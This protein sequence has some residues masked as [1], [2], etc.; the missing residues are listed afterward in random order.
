MPETSRDGLKICLYILLLPFCR[1][2][3][4]SYLCLQGYQETQLFRLA[5]NETNSTCVSTCWLADTLKICWCKTAKIYRFDKFSHVGMIARTNSL[6]QCLRSRFFYWI[7]WRAFKTVPQA[8]LTRS[9]DFS[10]L[11]RIM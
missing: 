2:N 9:F 1:Q 5:G 8:L 11:F 7:M 6:L 3:G 10:F 4:R